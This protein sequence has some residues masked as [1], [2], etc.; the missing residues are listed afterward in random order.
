MHPHIMTEDRT[1]SLYFQETY[2]VG[3]EFGEALSG[4]PIKVYHGGESSF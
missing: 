2:R 3:K 1:H 4:V